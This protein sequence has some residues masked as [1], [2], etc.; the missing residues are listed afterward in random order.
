M[1]IIIK[2]E[3]GGKEKEISYL[4]YDEFDEASGISSMSRTT[5]YTCTAAINLLAEKKFTE[6]G[7]FPPEIIGKE[8][9]ALN[10]F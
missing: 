5:G 9:V 4:L 3:T 6:K 10:I 8:K 2:G 7:V 1:K